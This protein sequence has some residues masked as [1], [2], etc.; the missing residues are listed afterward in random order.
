MCVC[1]QLYYVKPMRFFFA[2]M[3]TLEICHTRE[4]KKIDELFLG[5][6][7]TSSTVYKR[8][9]IAFI[10]FDPNF[11]RE[12]VNEKLGPNGDKKTAMRGR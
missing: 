3:R 8:T 10:C 9:W 5:I 1:L 4:R 11:S 2:V 12:I 6:W 7:E